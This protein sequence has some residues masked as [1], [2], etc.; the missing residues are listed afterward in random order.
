MTVTTKEAAVREGWIAEYELADK[1]IT[2]NEY[3]HRIQFVQ[4]VL[5]EAFDRTVSEA[6]RW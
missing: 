2:D 3:Q 4:E 6:G 1:I 5:G